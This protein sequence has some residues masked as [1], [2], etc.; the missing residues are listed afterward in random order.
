MEP[1]RVEPI[2]ASWFVQFD[3]EGNDLALAAEL[4]AMPPEHRAQSEA[5]W[6]AAI[7]EARAN[8]RPRAKRADP[9]GL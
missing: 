4:A 2:D 1:K 7:V 9:N 6:R 8:L 3:D 5:N